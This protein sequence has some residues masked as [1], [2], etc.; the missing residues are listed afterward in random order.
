MASASLRAAILQTATTS[1]D[2]SSQVAARMEPMTG[3]I[4]LSKAFPRP[5]EP[6]VI[7]NNPSIGRESRCLERRS[8]R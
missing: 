7:S 8:A 3:T 2:R 4:E 6:V 1:T 5:Y